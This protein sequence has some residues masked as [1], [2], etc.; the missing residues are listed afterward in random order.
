MPNT[1]APSSFIPHET[2]GMVQARYERGGGILD[3]VALISIVLFVASGALAGGVFLYKQYLETSSASKLDQ[4]QR[5][6]AAFEPSL[7]QQ[8]TRLDDRMRA[9]GQI[10]GSHI[11]PSAFFNM[12]ASTT[13]TTVAFNTFSFQA[14][15]PQHMTIRMDGV[16]DSVNSVALQADLFSKGGMITSPI[17]SNIDRE[18]DGVHLSLSGL[19]NPHSINYVQLASGAV[20]QMLPSSQT[21]AAAVPAA[22]GAGVSP[23]GNTPPAPT[24]PSGTQSP[25]P[26]AGSNAAGPQASPQA[27]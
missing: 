13:I 24:P 20:L 23:F 26:N 4:L 25:A 5:A 2:P 11:A 21:G 22:S 18:Q 1:G 17:F 7:I 16:A 19:M 6:Q 3:L 15:D 12:L 10:L 27:Q 8:L 14:T 9:A